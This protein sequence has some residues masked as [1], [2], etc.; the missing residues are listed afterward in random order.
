MRMGL[1]QGNI[2][3]MGLGQG[4]IM[5]MGLDLMF[6]LSESTVV[7]VTLWVWFHGPAG[8]EVT[9]CIVAN[10]LRH[11]T[12]LEGHTWREEVGRGKG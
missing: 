5:G 9:Y 8:K 10:V 3:G 7:V 11:L 12:K 2:M 6:L 4:N 1:G